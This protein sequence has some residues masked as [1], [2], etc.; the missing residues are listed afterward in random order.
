[1]ALCYCSV[2]LQCCDVSLQTELSQV[3]SHEAE[4]SRNA[5]HEAVL[6]QAASHEAASSVVYTASFE[7]TF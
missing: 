7:S 3:A 2:I 4:L 1:M 5:S 6:S